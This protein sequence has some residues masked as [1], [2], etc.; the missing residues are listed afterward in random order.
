[1]ANLR[2]P[3]YVRVLCG[4][5]ENL[6]AAFAAVDMKRD[7]KS[8]MRISRDNPKMDLR[9][10]VRA[11]LEGKVPPPIEQEAAETPAH[12]TP[13]N[14]NDGAVSEKEQTTL[15]T[16]ERRQ[17]RSP[18]AH[19]PPPTNGAIGRDP[20]LPPAGSTLERWYKGRAYFV[21]VLDD[22][23]VWGSSDYEALSSVAR[24]ITRN[25]YDG[26]KFFALTLPWEQR[27]PQIRGRR[28]NQTTLIDLAN[29]TEI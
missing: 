21:R 3:E 12:T 13:Q 10:R 2:F 28:L 7:T 4:S 22:G 5:I 29:P 1:V 25:T 19:Q 24:A 16:A 8:G 26:Y 9:R 15:H 23:F 27:A 11:L 18:R 20:R 14:H 17:S 6:P